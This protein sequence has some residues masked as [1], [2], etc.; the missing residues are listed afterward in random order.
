[1]NATLTITR[2]FIKIENDESE[3]SLLKLWANIRIKIIN[4]IHE[5]EE[6]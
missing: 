3:I 6:L 4:D 2:V 1:M 5:N